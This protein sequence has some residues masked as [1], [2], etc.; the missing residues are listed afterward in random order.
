ME[1]ITTA[2]GGKP[3]SLALVVTLELGD[4]SAE[5]DRVAQWII[6]EFKGVYTNGNSPLP[7]N[8]PSNFHRRHKKIWCGLV[9]E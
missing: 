9:F 4:V 6:D 7:R 3:V 8:S 2:G 1:A 5:H